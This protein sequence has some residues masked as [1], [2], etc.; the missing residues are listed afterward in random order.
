[1]VPAIVRRLHFLARAYVCVCCLENLTKD[2]IVPK[3]IDEGNW[4][5][6]YTLRDACFCMV[7]KSGMV[8]W[9]GCVV[10]S[11]LW[12]AFLV[13]WQAVVN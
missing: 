8:D 10:S 13:Y 1:M 5:E 2:R 11:I 7:F 9:K 12:A 4:C 6:L 3:E